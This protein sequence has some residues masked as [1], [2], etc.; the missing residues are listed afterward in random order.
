MLTRPVP[1]V[2]KEGLARQVVLLD[3]L[4]SQTADDLRLRSDGSVVGTRHPAGVEATLTRTAHENILDA[5]IEHVPHMQ[6]A[7]DVGWGDDDGIS[8]AVIGR[9]VEELVLHPVRIPLILH[10]LGAVL[11]S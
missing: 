1:S 6:Y 8:G 2:L 3:T 9:R 5:I 4:S 7:R 10:S 11:G